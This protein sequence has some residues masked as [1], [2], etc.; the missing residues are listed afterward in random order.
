LLSDSVLREY[1]FDGAGLTFAREIPTEYEFEYVEASNGA[2]VLSG[3]M[4]PVVGHDGDAALYSYQGPDNFVM[5]PDG[6]WGISWFSSG[7]ATEKYTFKD[8]ALVG[9]AM[10]FSEV[11]VISNLNI[12]DTYIY[13][14]GSSVEGNGHYVFVYDHSGVLQMQ[15]GGDP[16]GSFGLGSVTFVAKTVN[17]FLALDGNMREIVLWTADGTWLGAVED[18]DLFGTNY[19]WFATADVMADGSILVVMTEDRA[20]ESAMEAIS[21]K[22]TVS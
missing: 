15:L 12:D 14:A 9:E 6:T 17:G 8:G 18:S 16:N 19:P 13:V 20:D 21:F 22:I 7:D 11:K 5:A 4:Q 3:F 2:M 1:A 10:P